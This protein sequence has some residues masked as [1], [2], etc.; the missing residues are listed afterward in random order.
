MVQA[1]PRVKSNAFSDQLIRRW[2]W[3]ASFLMTLVPD[4]T[5]KNF[6]QTEDRVCY[7]THRLTRHAPDRTISCTHE[8]LVCGHFECGS[9]DRIGILKS[10]HHPK[11][12][13][14]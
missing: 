7:D 8:V 9:L 13:P 14:S 1:S 12:P 2:S 4:G 5:Y 6:S 3:I 11:D 10:Q